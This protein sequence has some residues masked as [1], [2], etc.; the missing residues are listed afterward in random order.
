MDRLKRNIVKKVKINTET[1]CWEFLGCVQKN[2]YGRVTYNRVTQG[3]HRWS[4]IAFVGEIPVGMDVC[5]RCDNRKCV[6]PAHL[7]V[8]TRKENMQDAKAKGRTATGDRLPQSKISDV[9]KEEILK[10]ARNGEEY[11][12]IAESIGVTKSSI[13]RIARLNGVFRYGERRK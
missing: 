4:Y 2:G 12:S 5:H 10:R 11:K 3:A 7:F 8:G 6:N 9:E 1:G 13:G